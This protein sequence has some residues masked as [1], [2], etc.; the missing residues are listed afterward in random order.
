[1]TMSWK[2]DQGLAGLCVTPTLQQLTN[3]VGSDLNV[4]SKIY[5]VESTLSLQFLKVISDDEFYY[6]NI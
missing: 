1:M 6:R 5:K 2:S 3:T 4:C